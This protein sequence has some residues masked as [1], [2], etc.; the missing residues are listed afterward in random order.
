MYIWGN[1]NIPHS[2]NIK[3][4]D[5]LKIHHSIKRTN[6][7]DAIRFKFPNERVFTTA[8]TNCL[9]NIK[10]FIPSHQYFFIE[11]MSKGYS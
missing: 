5:P 11:T 2:M 10:K 6:C 7:V 1:F 3:R 8:Q 9:G 4:K